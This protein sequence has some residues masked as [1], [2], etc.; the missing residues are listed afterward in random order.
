MPKTLRFFHFRPPVAT[1]G[2][3]ISMPYAADLID[4]DQRRTIAGSLAI[5]GLS[6]RSSSSRTSAFRSIGVSASTASSC[7][8]VCSSGIPGSRCG[9][10]GRLRC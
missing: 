8:W 5:A 4:D 9:I 10:G 7:C 1:Y 2:Y 3:Q 6:R